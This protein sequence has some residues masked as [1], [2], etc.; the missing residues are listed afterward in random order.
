MCSDSVF[1]C[2]DPPAPKHYKVVPMS[3]ISGAPSQTRAVIGD[4][5]AHRHWCAEMATATTLAVL[6]I[7]ISRAFGE[8]SKPT[9]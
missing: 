4:S 7:F 6:E 8:P 2:S 5:G 3:Y 1:I 9:A